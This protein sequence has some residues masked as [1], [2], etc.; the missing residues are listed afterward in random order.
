M[1]KTRNNQSRVSPRES[2]RRGD[3]RYVEIYRRFIPL[4]SSDR[5]ILVIP[6]YRYDR[7]RASVI[8]CNERDSL[9]LTRN[10]CLIAKSYQDIYVWLK[11]ILY[12]QSERNDKYVLS[13]GQVAHNLSKLISTKIISVY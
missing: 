7:C 5:T 8:Y 13:K 4:P 12:F 10:S 6:K 11:I 3:V 1:S 2:R 9:L